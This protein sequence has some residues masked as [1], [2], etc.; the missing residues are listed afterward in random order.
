MDTRFAPT[1]GT[2][3]QHD[4]AC[5]LA[6]KAGFCNLRTALSAWS[7]NSVSKVKDMKMNKTAASKFITWLKDQ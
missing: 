1:V 7:G 2:P 4:Y 5:A 6:S 3:K